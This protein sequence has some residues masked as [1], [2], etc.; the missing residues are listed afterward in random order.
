MRP[1]DRADAAP[2]DPVSCFC[3][4]YGRPR[5]LEEAIHSF[6]LQDYSGPKEMIVLNDYADQILAFDHHEVRVVNY[7]RRFPSLGEK[8]NAAVAL[9][10]HD[11]LFVWDDDDIYLPH[12][13]S[14]SMEHF[15]SSKGFF[16]PNKAWFW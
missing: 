4:T 8:L 16:K 7:S 9:A 12:R 3:L 5:I 11:L 13:L 2:L 15:D 10:S 14:F 1:Q 6:L